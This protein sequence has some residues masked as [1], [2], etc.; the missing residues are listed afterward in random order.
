M[1][2]EGGWRRGERGVRE[3]GGEGSRESL[4]DAPVSCHKGRR[5]REGREMIRKLLQL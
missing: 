3:G 4:F 1:G 2:S 5:E